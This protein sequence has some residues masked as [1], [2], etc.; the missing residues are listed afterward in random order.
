MQNARLVSGVSMSRWLDSRLKF[1]NKQIDLLRGIRVSTDQNLSP[2]Q[3]ALA[4]VDRIYREYEGEQISLLLSGG[5]DSQAMLISWVESGRPFKAYHV[6]YMDENLHDRETFT[7]AKHLNVEIEIVYFDVKKFYATEYEQYV[8]AY[9][10]ASPH[11]CVHMAFCS[12]IPG[13]KVFSGTPAHPASLGLSNTIYAL[14]RYAE[15]HGDVV[16]FFFSSTPEIICSF[17]KAYKNS[18][19]KEYYQR[20]IDVYHT[21]GFNVIPQEAKKSG[22]EKIREY[23]ETALNNLS[24]KEK[25]LYRS[26]YPSNWNFD[27]LFRHRYNELY[28]NYTPAVVIL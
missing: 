15:Q 12:L 5:A 8:T 26:K 17:S 16:P 24:E 20:K 22:F 13:I 23:Y 2:K 10:C 14:A 27:H 19:V 11:I 3:A 18:D 28:P 9:R 7:L 21:S 1:H 25:A 4:A 6:S